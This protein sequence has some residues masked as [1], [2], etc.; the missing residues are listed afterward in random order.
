MRQWMVLL[1][2]VAL[3]MHQLHGAMSSCQTCYAIPTRGVPVGRA[4]RNP[5]SILKMYSSSGMA[6]TR[7]FANAATA[8]VILRLGAPMPKRAV[9]IGAASVI[10]ACAY[11][12]RKR[13]ILRAFLSSESDSTESTSTKEPPRPE[14]ASKV[15]IP[16]P[17][18]SSM[19][20]AIG[21]Y[22]NFISPMLPPACRFL[23]TC[24]TYGVQA[25]QTYGATKGAILTAWR[26]ARCTPLG[27]K[28]YDPPKWPPVPYNYGS[29]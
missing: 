19:I 27:G 20:G 17:L 25:I 14:D 8:A 26:L 7:N 11:R 1:F 29:Y 9:A 28:G 21:F 12:H 5:S 24:S 6:R 23:P 13:V 15:E 16:N 10:V 18:S 4:T 22:K 3:L 2:R